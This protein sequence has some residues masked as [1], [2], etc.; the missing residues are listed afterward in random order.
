MKKIEKEALQ[1]SARE[2]ANLAAR[3]IRSLDEKEEPNAE[4]LWIQEAERRYQE[5]KRGNTTGQPSDEVIREIRSEF[6]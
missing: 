6:E 2:R 4:K 5:F 3:L 1:L